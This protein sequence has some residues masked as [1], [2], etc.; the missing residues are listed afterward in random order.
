MTRYTREELGLGA[1]RIDDDE[2]KAIRK[3]VAHL[4]DL[5]EDVALEHRPEDTV[6]ILDGMYDVDKMFAGVDPELVN[7]A[8]A[9]IRATLRGTPTPSQNAL[10]AA[11]QAQPAQPATPS[12][13]EEA[14]EKALLK[15]ADLFGFTV[16]GNTSFV[17]QVP[18][19]LKHLSDRADATNPDNFVSKQFVTDNCYDKKETD[20]AF[21][22]QKA[23]LEAAHAKDIKD[24]YVPKAN[25]VDKKDAVLKTD[26]QPLAAAIRTAF[27]TG[28]PSNIPGVKTF[29]VPEKQ[30]HTIEKSL[31]AIDDKLKPPSST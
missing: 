13:N 24:N 2:K 19:L 9:A 30:S 21:D 31:D 17:Q 4:T 10:G 3:A 18:E 5:A 11:P 6:K 26:I 16:F 8:V 14:F 29:N 23:D 22:K 20:K 28:K 1:R 7:D 15:I 12:D 25:A 27:A